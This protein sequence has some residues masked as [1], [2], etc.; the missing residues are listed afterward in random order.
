MTSFQDF[1]QKPEGFQDEQAMDWFGP[2]ADYLL[3]KTKIVVGDQALRIT[4]A[5][6]YYFDEE[7][8]P[9]YFA[10][11]DPLQLA[12]GRWY[13]HRMDGSYKAGSFKGLDISFGDGTAFGGV[14]IRGLEKPDGDLIDG[15]SLCV[16]H[17]LATGGFAKVALMDEAIAERPVWDQES[18]LTLVDTDEFDAKE[19]YRSSRVGLTLKRSFPGSN[20]PYYITRPYRFLTEP[21]RI[22]KGKIYLQMTLHREGLTPEEIN[23]LTGSPKSSILKNIAAYDEGLALEDFSAFI[24]KDLKTADLARLHGTA[25]AHPAP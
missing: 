6:F 21:R 7:T 10:H 24:R 15:P 17:L 14:L 23:K 22:K 13:F 5:E 8:H 4:E 19:V 12:F 18:P 2:A 11:R 1:F 25:S 9:D 3:N 20:M 16:D